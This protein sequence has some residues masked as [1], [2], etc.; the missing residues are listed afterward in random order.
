MASSGAGA[1]R[2]PNWARALGSEFHA[3]SSH[4]K[5]EDGLQLQAR[6]SQEGRV[7]QG[8]GGLET[9]FGQLYAAVNAAVDPNQAGSAVD[10]MNQAATALGFPESSK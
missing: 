10:G 3:I 4:S 5:D 8:A 2:T 1:N 6:R 7:P 9:P